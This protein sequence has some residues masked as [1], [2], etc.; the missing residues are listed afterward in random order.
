MENPIT[1]RKGI[2]DLKGKVAV[3]TGAAS[4]IGRALAVGLWDKGC[5]LALVDLDQ[6]GLASLSKTLIASGRNQ[7]VSTHVAD[8][9]DKI[10]MQA[11]AGEVVAAHRAVHVL[12]NNAGIGYEAAFPQTSLEDWERIVDVNLWGVIHGCHFFMPHLAKVERAHIVNLSSLFGIVAMPGQSAYCATKFAVRGFSESL[13]EELRATSVGLTVVHPGAVATSIMQHAKGDDPELLQRVSRWYERHA[14]SPERAAAQII[15]AIEKG[16]PRLVITPEAKFGDLLKRL[17]PVMRQQGICRRGDSRDRRRGHAREANRAVAGD[18]GRRRRDQMTSL[19][20]RRL[21][22]GAGISGIG[23]GIELRREA[24]RSFALLEAA[25]DLGGTWRDNTY[26][27]IAVDIPS[28][29]YCFSFET[30]YPWSREFATGAE[31]QRYV[32]HCA[33]KYGVTRH[34]RITRARSA[35]EFDSAT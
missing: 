3:V 26:P 9:G 20:S 2:R 29:S 33:E 27:G 18:H 34:I 22:V 19:M 4:G 24:Y 21:I 15:R 25:G 16:T 32:R 10:R 5:H 35:R 28:V 7:V 31:I 8:V 1:A 6:D 14:M 12:I 11:L 17:L 23:A 30:D 13:W